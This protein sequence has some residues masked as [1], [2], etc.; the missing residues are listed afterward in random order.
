M[1]FAPVPNLIILDQDSTKLYLRAFFI[2]LFHIYVLS[3]KRRAI[4]IIIIIIISIVMIIM[5]IILMKEIMLQ[6]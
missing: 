3:N 1:V 5:I 2:H 6:G 4:I